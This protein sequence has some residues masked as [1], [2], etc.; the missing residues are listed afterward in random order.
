MQSRRI[1][2]FF[3]IFWL[4]ISI[5]SCSKNTDSSL[6][7]EPSSTNSVS[8]DLDQAELSF[9]KSVS[10]NISQSKKAT[11]LLESS[12][13]AFLLSPTHDTLENAQRTLLNT[14]MDYAGLHALK[15]LSQAAPATFSESRSI[16]FRLQ[17]YP[18]QPGFLD[19]FGVYQYSGLVFDIG[20]PINAKNLLQQHGL[21]DDEE[22]VLGIHAI[23]FMLFGTAKD[24]SPQDYIEVNVLNEEH[25]KQQ[26]SN[27]AEAPSNRRR[28]LLKLQIAQLSKDLNALEK[29][30]TTLTKTDTGRWRKLSPQQQ[31]SHARTSLENAV[32]QS[33]VQLANM[34]P[35]KE[36]TS[37]DKNTVP[38]INDEQSLRSNDVLILSAQ[39]NALKNITA[40]MSDIERDAAIV[41]LSDAQLTLSSTNFNNENRDTLQAAFQKT[42]DLLKSIL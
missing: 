30:L 24:R 18:I 28:Q 17:A 19:R 9:W 27:I 37:D 32:T 21:T 42:Y 23:A 12:V 33:L 34:L 20:F 40:Y 16:F 13:N 39:L 25:R 1:G 26:L 35:T 29:Q 11:R 6:D 38:D 4:T 22:V 5:T 7:K 14:Q 41:A 10:D 2:L 15:A 3:F 31:I 36:N 8:L